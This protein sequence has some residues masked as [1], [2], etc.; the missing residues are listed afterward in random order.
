MLQGL[1]DNIIEDYLIEQDNK[2][3]YLT[4][5]DI[6]YR[7]LDKHTGKVNSYFEEQYEF[8]ANIPSNSLNVDICIKPIKTT[9]FVFLN[10][11]V[12]AS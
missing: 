8:T 3:H 4:S 11:K 7:S 9:E 6:C 2:Y 10:F 12:D 1:P 5:N